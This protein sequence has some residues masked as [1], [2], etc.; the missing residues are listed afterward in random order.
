MNLS[1]KSTLMVIATTSAA[2]FSIVTPQ[3]AQAQALPDANF[4]VACGSTDKSIAQGTLEQYLA[5]VKTNPSGCLIGDK[6]FK[7]TNYNLFPEEDTLISF[8]KLNNFTYTILAQYSPGIPTGA[9]L[10]YDATITP[11]PGP[12]GQTG[13]DVLVSDSSSSLIGIKDYAITT[14]ANAGI[15]LNL[16]NTSGSQQTSLNLNSSLLSVKNEITK[17]QN[18]PQ[19]ITNTFSQKSVSEVPGP[20]PLLGAGLA[21]GYSRKLRSRIKSHTLV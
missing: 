20:L 4:D 16:T 14:T 6:L 10:E 2:A 13:Y 5:Y 17:S 18:G 8:T 21:F 1:L 15:P 11:F 12:Q 3:A 9:I 7:L 19:Q